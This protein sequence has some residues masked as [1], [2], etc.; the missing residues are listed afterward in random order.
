M[1]F[2]SRGR[3]RPHLRHPGLPHPS[4][5]ARRKPKSCCSPKV[6]PRDP[7]T[8]QP[9]P[10]HSCHACRAVTRRNGAQ[11]QTE[12]ATC[13][14][15]T[16]APTAIEA[17]T[18][19]DAP[20]SRCT[21]QCHHANTIFKARSASTPPH[22]S[23]WRCFCR[24]FLKLTFKE[25]VKIDRSVEKCFKSRRPPRKHSFRLP[26]HVVARFFANRN[27][28]HPMPPPIVIKRSRL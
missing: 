20:E 2:R 17:H 9:S 19:I 10:P 11:T 14:L 8:R 5:V 28:L 6:A 16:R 27:W 26:L 3:Q 21:T 22:Q 24:N 12:R 13:S 1:L 23:I 18:P 25:V 15:R 4:G 7:D